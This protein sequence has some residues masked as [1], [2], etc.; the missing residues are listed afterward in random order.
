MLDGLKE[1]EKKNALNEAKMLAKLK[2]QNIIR[3]KDSFRDKEED[4]L[5]IL[6]EYAEKGDLEKLINEQRKKKQF[7]KES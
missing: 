2:H 3:F 5:C 7:L 1:K 4:W 6:M